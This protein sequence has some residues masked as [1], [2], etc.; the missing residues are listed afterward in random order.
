MHGCAIVVLI[1]AGLGDPSG[2]G[3]ACS[4]LKNMKR[5]GKDPVNRLLGKPEAAAITGTGADLRKLQH[6]EA[7]KLLREKFQVD[8]ETIDNLNRWE[9]IGVLRHLSTEAVAKG[10][11]PEVSLRSL[12]CFSCGLAA[13][14]VDMCS[15]ESAIPLLSAPSLS[16]TKPHDYQRPKHLLFEE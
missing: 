8:Q 9:R 4:F 6:K 1:V 7:G 3:I 12:P 15:P 11:A 5:M 2:T 14:L 16:M 13:L 10:I